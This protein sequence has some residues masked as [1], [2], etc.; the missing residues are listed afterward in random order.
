VSTRDGF[1]SRVHGLRH[2]SLEDRFEL[3]SARKETGAMQPAAQIAAAAHE[4]EVR[5]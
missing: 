2:Q 3:A 5:G 4:R 1:V